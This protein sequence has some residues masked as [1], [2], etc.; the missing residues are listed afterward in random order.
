MK[1]RL[2][3][4][5]MLGMMLA[6]GL[7]LIGCGG[8]DGSVIGSDGSGGEQT[9]GTG[10]TDGTG[11]GT[12]SQATFTPP[13]K[14]QIQAFLESHRTNTANKIGSENAAVYIRSITVNTYT[15]NGTS[16]TTNPADVAENADVKVKF[17]LRTNLSF[18]QLTVGER[19]NIDNYRIAL[20]DDLK[21]WLEQQGFENVP[22]ANITTGNTVFG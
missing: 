17:T 15:I 16:I 6:L 7:V 14:A 18:A 5:A 8:S 21:S 13:T 4:M 3:L 19:L 10:E 2:V 22:F 9:G 12:T 20:M 11:D 1:K